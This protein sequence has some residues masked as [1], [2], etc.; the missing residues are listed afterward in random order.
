MSLLIFIVGWLAGSLVGKLIVHVVRI[1]K[2]DQALESA[3][4]DELVEKAGYR[5]DSGK[6]IGGLFKWFII[7]V[8]LV[9]ALD[10]LGL[11]QVNQFL[12]RAVLSY[13]PNVIVVVLILLLAAVIGETAEKLVVASAK[14]ASFG[15]SHFL[16]VVANW[17]IWIFAILVGLSQLGIAETIINTIFIG[18]VAMFALAGGLAF[19]LGGRDAAEKIIDN[20][21]DNMKGK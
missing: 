12:D 17:A 8:F 16:G 6:F 11:S 13:L 20:V 5:L 15:S 21:V 19:G 4:V 2:I 9:A 14:A 3:G 7:L 1:F 18:M 10:V